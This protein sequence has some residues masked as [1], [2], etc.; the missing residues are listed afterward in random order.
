MVYNIG[1]GEIKLSPFVQDIILK[2]NDLKTLPTI[3]QTNK[4]TLLDQN[5]NSTHKVQQILYMQ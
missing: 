2:F 3:K 5:T 4:K 1:Q